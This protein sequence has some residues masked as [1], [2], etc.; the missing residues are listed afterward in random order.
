MGTDRNT[1]V[2]WSLILAATSLHSLFP[3]VRPYTQSLCKLP[4]PDGEG[5]YLQGSDDAL[6]V[7]GWLVLM[8]ALRAT[9]IEGVDYAAAWLGLSKKDR[10]RFAEQAYLMFYDGTSFSIGMV[11][12]TRVSLPCSHANELSCSTF[13]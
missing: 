10:L 1:E 7:L 11:C 5:Q 3:S 4:Y 2:S 6:F 13:L 9:M 12:S 8:T